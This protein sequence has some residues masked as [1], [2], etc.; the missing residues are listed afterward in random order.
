MAQ[1]IQQLLAAVSSDS[2]ALLVANANKSNADSDCSAAISAVAAALIGGNQGTIQSTSMAL[3]QVNAAKAVTD[4]AYAAA[5][6][7]LEI[8]RMALETAM[9]AALPPSPL[10]P[11]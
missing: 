1:T 5:V 2:T 9:A 8:D 3:L 11:P 4:A 6:A 7:Q 10:P